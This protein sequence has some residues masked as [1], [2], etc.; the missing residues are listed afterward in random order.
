MMAIRADSGSVAWEVKTRTPLGGGVLATAGR[1]VFTGDA[2]GNFTAYSDDDGRALWS[3]Q[4]GSG[5]RAAP[6]TYLLDG[7]Q[8]I[9]IP[10]GMS[11]AVGGYTGAGAPWMKN[12][13]GGDT[14]YVFALFNPGGSKAFH[15]G[16]KQ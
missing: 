7:R 10:S 5:I 16:A 14:L 4:T 15:G 13:R 1:L 6:I 3:Y 11:G 12:Y 2:E 9:A 8:Y